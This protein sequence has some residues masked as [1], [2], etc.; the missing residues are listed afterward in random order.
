MR[1]NAQLGGVL[2]NVFDR[3][4]SVGF[5]QRI[6]GFHVRLKLL[7]VL[8]RHFEEAVLAGRD[9]AILENERRHALGIEPLGDVDP[10]AV[11]RKDVEA[12]ARTDDD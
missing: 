4:R 8:R 12:A 11:D 6:R 5:G 3:G 1:R 2:A 7:A 10:F 9:Q